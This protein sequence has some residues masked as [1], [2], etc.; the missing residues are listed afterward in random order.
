[1]NIRCQRVIEITAIFVVHRQLFRHLSLEA[2]VASR[3]R[4]TRLDD[5]INAEDIN[6]V[7]VSF[8]TGPALFDRLPLLERFSEHDLGYPPT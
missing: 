5:G 6:L 4:E 2:N 1:M 3:V 8:N 7:H